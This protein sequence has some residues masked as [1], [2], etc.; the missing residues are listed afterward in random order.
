MSHP[1][2]TRTRITTTTSLNAYSMAT[3][4]SQNL[5]IVFLCYSLYEIVV[6]QLTVEAAKCY[7]KLNISFFDKFLLNLFVW[8]FRKSYLCISIFDK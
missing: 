8:Y 5:N 2:L 6:E 1:K 3:V 7:R 4:I